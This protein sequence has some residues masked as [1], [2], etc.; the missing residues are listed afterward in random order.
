M[1][2]KT[3]AIKSFIQHR[4]TGLIL[5]RTYATTKKKIPD[6]DEEEQLPSKYGLQGVAITILK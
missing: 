6:P 1:L 4:C 2:R 3:N 5:N